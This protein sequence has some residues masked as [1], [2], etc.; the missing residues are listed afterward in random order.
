[1]EVLWVV[2]VNSKA[3]VKVE[4]HLGMAI[5]AWQCHAAHLARAYF[6]ICYTCFG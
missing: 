2:V 3:K 5:R 1:M 4:Q 6:K